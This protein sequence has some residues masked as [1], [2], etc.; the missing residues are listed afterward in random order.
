MRLLNRAAKAASIIVLLI[1]V[2][3]VGLFLWSKDKYAV[4]VLMYHNIT[5][6][7]SEH[8]MNYVSP[9]SF[10]RQMEFLKRNG[11]QVL[12][13]SEFVE[14]IR[15]SRDFHRKS[16]VITFD[17]GY[18]DNYTDAFPVLKKYGF[19]ATVF[20]IADRVGDTGYV[21]WE[22]LR[23]M[24]AAGF[25]VQSHTRRH[26]YLPD[27][28]DTAMLDDEIINSKRI[29]ETYLRKPVDYLCYPKG[30]FNVQVAE[31]AQKA[32]YKAAVT[33]N[34]GDSRVDP[35]FQLRRIRVNDD[36]TN[37]VLWA[38]TSGYYN[39]FRKPKKSH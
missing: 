23:E 12:T 7:D 2:S 34:R 29:L 4:P 1:V 37:I 27:I 21:T 22:S 24:D 20:M 19:P 16:V 10:D 33:T 18:A 15:A 11:F 13:L 39:L 30:G 28:K 26:E 3:A 35:F 31:I 9:Q 5:P 25:S 32:G 38:K 6:P 17:D 14:G 36:D 8:Q